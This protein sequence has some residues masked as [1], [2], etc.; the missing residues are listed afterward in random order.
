M[1]ELLSLSQISVRDRSKVGGKALQLARLAQQRLPVPDAVVVPCSSMVR[2]LKRTGLLEE[3]RSLEA[4][5]STEGARR[6][7]LALTSSS[8]PRRWSLALRLRVRRLGGRVA[9]RSSAVDEDG[10]SRSFAG[11]HLTV[12]NVTAAG[13]EEA[14]LRSW[15]SLYAE[16]ALAYRRGRGPSAGGMAVVIQRMLDPV[17]SGVMFTVNPMNGSWREMV[18]EATWGL[19]EGLVSGQVAPHWYLVRRPRRAPRPVQRVLS[20]VRLQ[21]IQED[22]PEIPLQWVCG[23]CGDVIKEPAPKG[24][25]TLEHRALFR[26]CRLGLRVEGALGSP[27]DVEWALDGRGR[28]VVLQARPITTTGTP[29]VRKDVL[30]TRRFIG[31]RWPDPA[32]PLGWSI[33]E[34]LL[35][36]FIAYPDT[37]SRFLGGGPAIRLEASR[38]YMNVT[39]FRH[40]AFKLP[41]APPPRFMLELIPPEEE[42]DWRKRFAAVPDV[43]VYASIL[44][45]TFRERRWRRFRWNP[46]TNHLRWNDFRARLEA[47]L[48]ELTQTPK[49]MGEALRLAELQL[50]YV[51][52]YITIHITS[53]LFANLFYQVLEAALATWLP[54][55][56]RELLEGLAVCPPGNLTLA[57]NEAL[58]ELA[59]VA[60]E[61][62]LVNLKEGRF[63]EDSSF[64]RALTVFLS[65][66]GH[67]SAA[68]WEIFSPRWGGSPQM[69][70][71]L[72]R[73]Q[74]AGSAEQPAL[75]LVRQQKAYADCMAE[76]RERIDNR[77]LRVAAEILIHYT[78]RYLLLRENQRFWFDRL[79]YALQRTLY[80]MGEAFVEEGWLADSSEIAF[81]TWEEIRGLVGGTLAPEPVAEWVERRQ[82]QRQKDLL[83]EPPIF[84]IGDR[85]V[86]HE[87]TQC[88]M[89]GLGIS[90][91]RTRGKVR[92]L[93]SVKDGYRV[94]KGDVLVARAAD[95]GWTPLFLTAGAVILEMGG[96]LSHGAVV[97][98]EYGIP[99]VVNLEGV[100]RQLID[101]QEVTVDGT[102]GLVWVHP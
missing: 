49:Q 99:G 53:L 63:S 34:P 80:G 19:G 44:R 13:V 79:L 94:E 95:P 78:R 28:P 29:R 37:Q 55:R 58:W 70:V 84:L 71:P 42:A 56:S 76:V 39:V 101:G 93:H 4:L 62:E 35:N 27:Q 38:P 9:V 85:G 41:G 100:T 98:R 97:A 83:S 92:I 74:L 8:L 36:W 43:A 82:G 47:D 45:E 77:A 66:Y 81:L 25:R 64:G 30:W 3:A 54:R 20:R 14:L 10:Q 51:R 102:R 87:K 18:V 17:V 11:Q 68:S 31:E 89:Q 23:E 90:P 22:L 50:L 96:L 2:H 52:D 91:G 67:R 86:A 6:L 5:P 40:L 21:L 60:T 32:T 24:R 15:A 46:F 72:L 59:Q 57:T 73:A 26:L 88:R 1:L 69:L 33:L 48:P 7:Q 75:R 65:Q 12:L 16:E 61:E